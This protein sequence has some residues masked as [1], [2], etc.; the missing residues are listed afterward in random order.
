MFGDLGG[1]DESAIFRRCIVTKDK[2][3]SF[4]KGNT[5]KRKSDDDVFN[6]YSHQLHKIEAQYRSFFEK[7]E[8]ISLIEAQQKAYERQYHWRG[9]TMPDDFRK[10]FWKT[11]RFPPA[12]Y[13]RLYHISVDTLG[14]PRSGDREA[15]IE[16]AECFVGK[17]TAQPI[18]SMLLPVLLTL[19][20]TDHVFEKRIDDVN[21]LNLYTL[22]HYYK[23]RR[24]TTS[25]DAAIQAFHN[26]YTLVRKCT[27][28]KYAEG[29]TELL[30]KQPLSIPIVKWDRIK[31]TLKRNGAVRMDSDAVAEMLGELD[32]L[33]TK[34]G[35]A[36]DYFLNEMED[37]KKTELR[38]HA[39]GLAKLFNTINLIK[40]RAGDKMAP[41][42]L[43]SIRN[44]LD[45]PYSVELF[46]IED[47]TYHTQYVQLLSS[48]YCEDADINPLL[49]LRYYRIP[50]D[51]VEAY[52]PAEANLLTDAVDQVSDS[53][54]QVAQ[55]WFIRSEF[56]N[57]QDFGNYL[58]NKGRLLEVKEAVTEFV[59]QFQKKDFDDF[60][61]NNRHFTPKGF[62]G[63]FESFAKEHNLSTVPFPAEYA[64]E[65][66]I[67]ALQMCKLVL[68]EKATAYSEAR[69]NEALYGVA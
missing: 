10:V 29:D 47:V 57:G 68:H 60:V 56:F 15:W 50:A 14:A 40:L 41:Q 52:M 36:T 62:V 38:R 18:P 21:A 22:L 28:P 17:C 69:I 25:E 7:L 32:A 26:V 39:K 49:F 67:S 51:R 63:Y 23:K 64:A 66:Y 9:K 6:G 11:E 53:V 34:N 54:L 48:R 20:L 37:C 31:E 55:M 65:L 43:Q 30:S 16:N 5:H 19:A 35:P 58:V 12:F 59:R 44:Y 3:V 13:D 27:D 42:T 45:G 4:M 8:M 33:R 61:K 24:A 2:C 1:A 46:R